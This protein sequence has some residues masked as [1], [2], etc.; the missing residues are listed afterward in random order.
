MWLIGVKNSIS[1][2]E[3]RS[4]GWQFCGLVFEGDVY[5]AKRD[6]T[7]THRGAAFSYAQKGY[8]STSLDSMTCEC[9]NA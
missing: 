2:P 5:L 1:A 3:N 7:E 9:S 4:M 8:V 6:T